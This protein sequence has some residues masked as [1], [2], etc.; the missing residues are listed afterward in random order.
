MTGHSPSPGKKRLSGGFGDLNDEE[1]KVQLMPL[2]SSNGILEMV[3]MWRQQ[4]ST[5]QSSQI[6][7]TFLFQVKY[8]LFP[9]IPP[10]GEEDEDMGDGA[11]IEML[12]IQLRKDIWNGR[13]A[14]LLYYQAV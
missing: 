9:P 8:Y 11:G 7:N 6:T 1:V 10:I 14:L 4:Q 12:Y 13:L 5:T 2:D 3:S